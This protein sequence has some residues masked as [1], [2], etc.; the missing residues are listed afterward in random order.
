MSKLSGGRVVEYIHFWLELD[1]VFIRMELC[2]DNLKN[3]LNKKPGFFGREDT[4]PMNVLEYSISCQ[5]FKELLECVQYL[6]ESNPPVIHRDLKPQNILISVN[7]KNKKC[8]KICDFG[9]ATFHEM[10]S[11]YHTN[12]V[13]TLAYIAP[14]VIR[15]KSK[16]NIK[17]DL[18]SLGKIFDELFD[19]DINRYP[20]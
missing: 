16:Y 1:T 19:I 11:I 10:T 17:A 5:I 7:N 6:H 18:F 20:L 12:G 9:L 14:E 4:E 8:L 3:L 2:S 15:S 13:G